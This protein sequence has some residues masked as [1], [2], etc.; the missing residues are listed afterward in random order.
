MTEEEFKQYVSATQGMLGQL[1]ERLGE[2]RDAMQASAKA[3]AAALTVAACAQDASS[4]TVRALAETNVEFRTILLRLAQEPAP[5]PAA[6][7]CRDLLVAAL[8]EH[9]R[10]AGE[11][12][13]LKPVPPS[14][15]KT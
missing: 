2:I 13:Q 14:G 1:N 4:L 6:Q 11:R 12:P 3:Q 10:I 15:K 8:A 5:N 9:Q 7:E